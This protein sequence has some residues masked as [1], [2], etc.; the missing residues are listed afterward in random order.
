MSLIDANGRLFGKANLIDVVVGGVLVG[1]VAL[2]IG[3]LQT[4][5]P[6]V[7][8]ITAVTPNQIAEKQRALLHLEGTGIRPFL[9]VRFG[10]TGSAG[11]MVEDPTSARVYVPDLPAG[12]YD[13]TVL[14]KG[15]IV[16]SFPQALTVMGER[17][18]A[19]F[20]T[21]VQ[22]LGSFVAM[23]EQEAG[24][25]AEGKD[26][27][28]AGTERVGRIVAVQARTSETQPLTV[29]P[30][31]EERGVV[32]KGDVINVPVPGQ[33]RARAIVKLHCT[34]VQAECRV[35]DAT[36]S[37]GKLMVLAT[38]AG[39][40]GMRFQ[41]EEVR[42][43]DAVP[44]FPPAGS[45]VATVKVRFVAGPEVI[46]ALSAGDIDVPGFGV[47]ADAD[48]AVLVQVGADRERAT[49]LVTA[50]GILRRSIQVEQSV[51]A[52]TATLRVPVIY[53][54][55]GWK[56]KERA[57]KVGAAFHFETIAGGMSG[58]VVDMSLPKR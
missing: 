11:L 48:R 26:V 39:S 40:A 55:T 27:F 38:A 21:D 54:A 34:V 12:T 47:V 16:F 25:L 45:A 31:H 10:N 33:F 15:R 56:Y 36:V 20:T 24:T 6:P 57:V 50:E 44:A 52:V 1:V 13:I 42:P 35:G 5:R 29:S 43:A 17:W 19:A 8:K 7:P 14:D 9:E 23:S 49:A 28:Q 58:L 51:V 30:A 46:N 2:A 37:Q 41:V 4:F 18:S 53:D 22:A 32:I 3:A